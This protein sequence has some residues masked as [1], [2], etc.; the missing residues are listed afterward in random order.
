MVKVDLGIWG[1]VDSTSQPNPAIDFGDKQQLKQ[2]V[3]KKCKSNVQR[4]IVH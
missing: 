2:R 3:D 1:F 4:Q